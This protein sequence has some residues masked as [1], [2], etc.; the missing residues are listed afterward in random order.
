MMD[1]YRWAGL[2]DRMCPVKHACRQSHT[3]TKPQTGT[4]RTSL[5][6]IIQWGYHHKWGHYLKLTAL[7]WHL[8][9]LGLHYIEHLHRCISIGWCCSAKG[10]VELVSRVLGLKTW[11]V[12]ST[13][14]QVYLVYE[15]VMNSYLLDTL[16]SYE[17]FRAGEKNQKLW[18]L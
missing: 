17:N 6:P 15:I 4:A 1:K 13:A 5:G 7:V 12:S 8:G 3:A 2:S 18:K 16:M 9:N 10:L 14:L 11:P